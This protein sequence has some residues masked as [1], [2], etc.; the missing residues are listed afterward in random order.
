MCIPS[1]DLEH[2]DSSSLDVEFLKTF[3]QVHKLASDDPALDLGE[4]RELKEA[5]EE[6]L[7]NDGDV[8]KE[9]GAGGIFLQFRLWEQGRLDLEDM[10]DR[11]EAIVKHALWEVVTEYYM[12]PNDFMA[13]TSMNGL[14]HDCLNLEMVSSLSII[15]MVN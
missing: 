3:V 6:G 11:L 9:E 14:C 7:N 4:V 12:M 2:N 1:G 10:L 8:E 5:T 15:L 13:S